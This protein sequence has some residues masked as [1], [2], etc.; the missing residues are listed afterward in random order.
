M[1]LTNCCDRIKLCAETLNSTKN[2][3][4]W[5]FRQLFY[6]FNCG[7]YQCYELI[8]NDYK[9]FIIYFVLL[10]FKILRKLLH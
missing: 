7:K 4:E 8:K 5:K 6:L 9:L 10:M 2:E 1:L 3:I